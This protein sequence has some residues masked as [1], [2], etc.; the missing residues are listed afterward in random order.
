MLLGL[1]DERVDLVCNLLCLME[2][3]EGCLRRLSPVAIIP[4]LV[5][6]DEVSHRSTDRVEVST[7]EI[8]FPAKGLHHHWPGLSGSFILRPLEYVPNPHPFLREANH[9]GGLACSLGVTLEPAQ[10]FKPSGDGLEG[11]PAPGTELDTFCLSEEL[12][13]MGCLLHGP[14]GPANLAAV[15][16][17]VVLE[18]PPV[19]P[20]PVVGMLLLEVLEEGLIIQALTDAAL[21]GDGC[22][23]HGQPIAHRVQNDRHGDVSDQ[24][25]VAVELLQHRHHEVVIEAGSSGQTTYM[26]LLELEGQQR[27]QLGPK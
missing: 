5:V 13:S 18:G 20:V 2:C 9:V 27:H 19:D 1:V 22:A 11:Y 12:V 3:L 8:V 23:V 7:T 4:A 14:L 21:H 26:E 6:V 24:L 10:L 17:D 16:Q 25:V 15:G